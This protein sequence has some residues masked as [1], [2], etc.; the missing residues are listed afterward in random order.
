MT[1]QTSPVRISQQF[2]QAVGISSGGSRIDRFLVPVM[3]A[4]GGLY[5]AIQILGGDAIL[6]AVSVLSVAL[7]LALSGA[8]PVQRLILRRPFDRS[9][10]FYVGMFWVCS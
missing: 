8:K 3:L 9:H 4:I 10:A 5:S 7:L 2:L 1:Q 6:G